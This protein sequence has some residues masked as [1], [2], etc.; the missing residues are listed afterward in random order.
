MTERSEPDDPTAP[1]LPGRAAV[2]PDQEWVPRL[3]SCGRTRSEA[4]A[5]LRALLLRAAWHQVSRMPQASGLGAARRQE[6]VESAADEAT[7]SVL[8]RLGT[9]EGRSRFTTWAY[10][11]AIYQAGIEVRRAAWSGREIPLHDL[12]LVDASVTGSPAANAEGHAL[13][14]ALREAIRDELTPHQRQVTIALLVD[15][16]PI[17][18]LAHRLG[19]SRG[20]LYKT[21]HDARGR[22]R[23]HLRARGL[24]GT[25]AEARR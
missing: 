7:M 13:A 9:F 17:D 5:H 16:I 14:L 20:A 1:V 3:S 21:L 8:A 19:T 11:F 12:P 6:I 2:I 24:L 22:L 10:K 18:V 25:V 15:E 23:S 4:V